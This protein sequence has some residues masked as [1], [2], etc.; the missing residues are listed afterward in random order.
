MCVSTRCRVLLL[1]RLENWWLVVHLRLN[2]FTVL[3]VPSLVLPCCTFPVSSGN[4]M[5]LSVA[6]LVI[7]HG[8][9]NIYFIWPMFLWAMALVHGPL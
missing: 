5:R 1:E 4:I 7:L 2:S 6:C 3:K 9:R 8:P